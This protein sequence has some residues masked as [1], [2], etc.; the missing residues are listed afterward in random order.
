MDQHDPSN[1][2]RPIAR[3][4]VTVTPEPEPEMDFYESFDR[5]EDFAPFTQEDTFNNGIFLRR[6]DD[7]VVEYSGCHEGNTVGPLL[8]QLVFGGER[9]AGSSCN[10]S[11]VPRAVVPEVSGDSSRAPADD[12]RDPIDPSSVPAS[13]A[14]DRRTL[15]RRGRGTRTRFPCVIAWDRCPSRRRTF[16]TAVAKRPSSC[17]RSAQLTS[18]RFSSAMGA[19]GASA[20]SARAPTIYGFPAG[21]YEDEWDEE[22]RPVPVLGE[23]AGHDRPVRFDVYVSSERIYVTL[24]GKPAGCAILPEDSAFEDP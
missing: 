10:M 9:T 16:P 8:G 19:V 4:F 17:S 11:I 15:E 1:R 5:P 24:D 14:D 22:W 21:S 18:S 6:N 2:P 3:A 12:D 13:D 20:L 7:W 23:M